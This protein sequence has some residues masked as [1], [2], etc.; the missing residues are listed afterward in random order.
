MCDVLADL[1]LDGVDLTLIIAILVLSV[2][3]IGVS[4]WGSILQFMVFWK[5]RS[6]NHKKVGGQTAKQVAEQMLQSLGYTDIQVRATSILWLFF[7]YKWGN[8]Y[9]PTRK[10]IFLYRNILNKSTVTAIAIATQKVGLVIQH[11]QGDKKMAFRAKWEIWTRLAPNMFLPI[12]SIGVILD[13]LFYNVIGYM[14]IF[15]LVFVGIAV[16]YTL[17]AFYALFLIIPTERGAGD[18]ALATIQQYKLVPEQYLSNI[19][20][21]YDCQVKVY[22]AD[23]VLA[24]V[25]LIMDILYIILKS[26]M[27][28]K[29]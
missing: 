3:A 10:T 6:G 20:S 1:N 15:S 29:R 7:F 2:F 25:N 26:R 11:K 9:S 19:K 5:Y 27:L 28:S 21:L 14:G 8:R 22:I 17:I 12:V 4:I 23:F 24:I 13:V 18:I 16:L